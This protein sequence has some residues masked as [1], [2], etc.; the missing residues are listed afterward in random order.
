MKDAYIYDG[1]RT[2]R[3]RGRSN[4]SLHE[5]RPIMLLKS[6]FDALK[7]RHH[8]DTS[9]VE[10]C[11]LGCVT[12]VGEQGANIA[13][14]GVLHAGWATTIP[15]FQLNHFCASGLVAINLAAQ[16]VRAE[17]IDLAVAGGVEAMSRVTMGSD[18]GVWYMDPQVSNNLGFIPQGVSADLIA[19]L[20]GFSR[21]AVD[22]Y[23]LT[24]Q[25]RAA[26]ASEHGHFKSLVP[27]KDQNGQILLDHEELIRGNT[28]L[29]EL[30]KLNPS[31]EAMAKMAGFDAVA[32][33]KYPMVERINYVHHAGNSSGIVDGASLHLVGSLEIG[34][35]LG[36]KP[37]AKIRA[38]A[39]I[40]AEPTIMLKGPVPATQLVL[41][42]A[43]MKINDID[44]FEVNEAFAC[45]PMLYSEELKVDHAKLNVNG[46]AIA[47]GHP[48]GATGAVLVTMAMDE[49]ER[50]GK[51]TALITLCEGGGQGTATIIERV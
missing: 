27:F 45:V 10:D 16:A 20:Y 43:G 36:L 31:F 8:L 15:G 46:G 1:V 21:E 33:S 39:S 13:R 11:I 35:R 24:S 18:G 14:I 42:K 17:S 37:R 4:G 19:T 30:A 26:H 49:L 28:T 23:A 22:Q 12:P 3:G 50:S 7:E 5:V 6:L 38:F 47:M 9:L 51:G 44:I 2:P 25:Q 41:K 32:L 29:A 40:G 34:K 48:L